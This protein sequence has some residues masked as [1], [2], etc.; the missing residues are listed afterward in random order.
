MAKQKKKRAVKRKKHLPRNGILLPAVAMIYKAFPYILIITAVLF[1]G[2][3][4][5]SLL[6]NSNY[7]KIKKIEILSNEFP[8]ASSVIQKSLQSK[9]GDNIFRADIKMCQ[10]V[11]EKACPEL[12]NIIVQ[13]F[14]PDTLSVTYKVR[15]PICQVGS[16]YYYMVCDDATILP[17][18]QKLE[19]PNLIIVTGIRISA[20]KLAPAKQSYKDGLKRAIAIIKEIKDSDFPS[21]YQD[22]VKINIYDKNNPVL[23]LKDRTKIELGE[24]SFKEKESLLKEIIDELESKDKKAGVIDLRFEDV[25]VVPR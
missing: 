9:N 20:Q 12:K 16:G 6:L 11:I 19:E 3:I 4:T 2:K 1:A 21:Q 13:R 5:M 24:F 14:L 15:R 18:P 25:V 17:N 23:F 10:T 22:I 7:F 8:G